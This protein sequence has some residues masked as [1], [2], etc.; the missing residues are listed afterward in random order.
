MHFCC[1]LT[2]EL[3]SIVK[4][5]DQELRSFVYV[6]EGGSTV[7]RMQLPKSDRQHCQ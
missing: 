5:Y 6:L 4:E 1:H 3:L 7:T 2:R